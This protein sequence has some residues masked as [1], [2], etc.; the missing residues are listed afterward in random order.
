MRFASL[1]RKECSAFNGS[2]SL[3]KSSLGLSNEVM[4]QAV[5]D[6]L[7]NK[8]EF[9]QSEARGAAMGGRCNTVSPSETPIKTHNKQTSAL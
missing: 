9:A 3:L 7:N 1:Q 2:N 8:R 6:A 5:L 4:H